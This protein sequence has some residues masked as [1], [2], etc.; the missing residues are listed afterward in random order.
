MSN[1]MV[2]HGEGVWDVAFEVDDVNAVYRRAVESGGKVV[3]E[4]WTEHAQSG[5]VVMANIRTYGDSADG[6]KSISS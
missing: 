4:L 2:E 3:K 1:Y 5:E 6:M